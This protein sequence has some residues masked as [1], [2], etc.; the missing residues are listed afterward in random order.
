M[1]SILRQACVLLGLW[2]SG[3]SSVFAS[4][5]AEALERALQ[6]LETQQSEADGAW[7]GAD[8]TAS[9]LQTTAALSALQAAG[10]RSAAWYA[11][12]AWLGNHAATNTDTRTRRLRALRAGVANLRSELDLLVRARNGGGWGL[13]PRYQ[14]D[15]LD[16]A[17]A[18]AALRQVGSTLDTRE[19]LAWLRNVLAEDANWP[20]GTGGPAAGSLALLLEALAPVAASDSALREV[21]QTRLVTLTPERLASSPPGVHALAALAW[22]A[23]APDAAAARALIANLRAAQSATGDLAGDVLATSLLIRALAQAETPA[24]AGDGER[25]AIGDVALRMAINETLGRSALDELTRAD[26][27]QL[28]TLDLDG[29]GVHDLR[30]L[31][32]ASN[33]QSFI[34]GDSPIA[35]YSPLARLPLLTARRERAGEASEPP[36]L[37][38]SE[39]EEPQAVP[40]LP[41]PASWLLLPL[42]ILLLR[43]AQTRGKLAALLVG[44][45]F[46]GQVPA[47]TA[48]ATPGPLPPRVADGVQAISHRLLQAIGNAPAA[49]AAHETLET[50]RTLVVELEAAAAL[51][52]RVAHQASVARSASHW[53]PLPP[54]T[55]D[56]ARD[57]IARLRATSTPG[58]RGKNEN[59]L[60]LALAEQ[61]AALFQ[62]WATELEA[63]LAPELPDRLARLAALRRRLQVD[64]SRTPRL[65]PASPT[66]Q[67]LP[68]PRR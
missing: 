39:A 46:A 67:A 2:V 48:A 20:A 37:L 21:L 6:W 11:G 33:L 40:L 23:L 43:N 55:V 47:A 13:A 1:R 44:L 26:L 19:T 38:A 15:P 50:T 32:Y 8:A 7:H 51:N 57:L 36:A 59:P 60:P 61:R 4:T 27:A 28:G 45:A 30:G 65:G 52:T 34:A 3:S 53:S 41:T 56:R 31:E 5:N 68:A 64:N 10:R 16:S 66:L 12:Q 35:D 63:T 24:R 58:T 49:D 25:V 54:A 29:R 9:M 17:L 62:R 18:V 22:Q 42:G 14:R